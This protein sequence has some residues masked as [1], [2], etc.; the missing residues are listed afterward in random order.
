MASQLNIKDDATV[1]EVREYAAQTGRTVTATI[2]EAVRNDRSRRE[3]E[4]AER[5]RRANEL[6]DEVR[7]NM[8]PETRAMTSWEIMESIYDDN[9][10]D[11]FAR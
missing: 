3:E 6:I 8:P 2:R 5:I 7:R 9:E 11:G 1:R 4:I 10:P